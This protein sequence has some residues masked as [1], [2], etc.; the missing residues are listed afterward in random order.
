M[1]A[2]QFIM[3]NGDEVIGQLKD[4]RSDNGSFIM[5]D[6]FLI[7][8]QHSGDGGTYYIFKPWMTQQTDLN[9]LHYVNKAHVMVTMTPAEALVEQY[10][11]TLT[12]IAETIENRKESEGSVEII[13]SEDSSDSTNINMG[14]FVAG[15]D[16]K[17]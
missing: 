10:K 2:I 15:N 5:V 8:R 4:E 11:A 12:H 6:T 16:I 17:H 9:A 1:K 3:L 7:E 14:Y 13:S